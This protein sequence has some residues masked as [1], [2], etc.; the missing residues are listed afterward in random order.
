MSSFQR[1]AECRC[2]HGL[3]H[4]RRCGRQS[5]ALLSIWR[6]GTH[7]GQDGEKC[8]R[9]LYKFNLS[10]NITAAYARQSKRENDGVG[11]EAGQK[12]LYVREAQVVRI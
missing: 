2:T 10:H 6:Y 5:A 9:I 1:S 12:A 11:A 8:R 7:S 4:R 3:R